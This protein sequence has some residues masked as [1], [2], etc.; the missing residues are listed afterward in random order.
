MDIYT[1]H[2]ELTVD[3]FKNV[4]DALYQARTRWYYIGMA[5][6]IHPATLQD[7]EMKVNDEEQRYSN[8]LMTWLEEGEY[9]TWNTLATALRTI[10]VRHPDIAKTIED[11]YIMV[12][13]QHSAG[14]W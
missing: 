11:K 7:I 13:R 8:M 10:L 5:L 6:K 9:R 2:K 1:E 12:P 3:D 14:E 4:F